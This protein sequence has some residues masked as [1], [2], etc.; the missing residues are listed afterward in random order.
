MLCSCKT[1]KPLLTTY[2]T[3][4][5]NGLKKVNEFFIKDSMMF[6]FSSGDMSG[7]LIDILKFDHATKD[8]SYFRVDKKDY[9]LLIR[10]S[11]GKV[12]QDSIEFSVLEFCKYNNLFIE[13][14]IIN[15]KHYKLV[16]NRIKIPKNEILEKIVNAPVTVKFYNLGTYS[17]KL[18]ISKNDSLVEI[19]FH[20]NTSSSFHRAIYNYDYVKVVNQT[21]KSKRS[22]IIGG[23]TIIFNEINSQKSYFTNSI[24]RR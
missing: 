3:N 12:V 6:V 23:E 2:Q 13:E 20:L 1:T 19:F 10:T 17:D 22:I 21:T 9:S 4:D 7:C 11:Q 15:G 18:L 8:T 5:Y 14:L 24:L 16:D